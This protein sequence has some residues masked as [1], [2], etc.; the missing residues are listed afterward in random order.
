MAVFTQLNMEDMI[1]AVKSANPGMAIV[2][3][4]VG[5]LAWVGMSI[6][7]TAFM[8]R[9]KRNF[10][11]AFMAQ[12]TTGF[13][14]V[15]MPAGVG[16]AFVNLQFLRKSGYRNSAATAIMSAVVAVQVVM[17]VLLIVFV[18][19]FTGR[20]T[21]S[22]VIPTGTVAIVI[23]IAVLV[24]SLCMLIP[25]LRSLLSR[26]LMPLLRQYTHQLIAL[27]SQPLNLA[28]AAFGAVLQSVALGVSFWAALLA[29]GYHTNVIE[30][31]FLYL[32]SNTIG[33]AV[34]TPGGLGGVEAMLFAAF[35][36][37][38]VP[39]AIA[40][41]A[42]MLYRVLTYWIRIPLG[43]LSMKWLEKHNLI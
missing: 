8:D 42:T 12:V 1:S 13:T 31:T 36:S 30:T 23:G 18:G 28:I 25:P 34:P 26:K 40:M 17:T 4:L 19:L 32:L 38:G 35:T 33:S 14:A 22:S 39:G 5:C 20:N 9:S 29:F 7:L 11:A 37:T 21:L 6:T 3:F 15:S 43:A 2:C 10:F 24:V 16:P 41:S 27:L